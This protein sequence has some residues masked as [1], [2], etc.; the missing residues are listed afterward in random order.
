MK[1]FHRSFVFNLLASL[2]SPCL[3]LIRNA[4]TYLFA[5]IVDLLAIN[6]LF[7]NRK[8]N[9][10]F[11]PIVIYSLPKAGSSWLESLL[12]DYFSIK[13]TIPQ[14]S[15]LRQ[16]IHAKGLTSKLSLNT[17]EMRKIYHLSSSFVLIKSHLPPSKE[18]DDFHRQMDWPY[19]ILERDTLSAVKSA[20]KYVSN[21]P[22]HSLHLNQLNKAELAR[23]LEEDYSS[24][25]SFK[26]S[27]NVALS[28]R[29]EDLVS[30]FKPTFSSILEHLRQVPCEQKI[31]NSYAHVESIQ[32]K[33][34]TRSFYR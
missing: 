24:W 4:R 21:T 19:I 6:Q 29:Y 20:V 28:I 14:P 22:W 26:P 12:Q 16:E 8:R 17:K 3:N 1:I 2:P 33:F 25:L 18:L 7:F 5:L 13:L 31:L 34:G 9:T 11:P 32:K 30:D 15:T 23:I 10:N 27:S